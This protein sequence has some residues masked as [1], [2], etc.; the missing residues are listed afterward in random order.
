MEYL[1]NFNLIV[2]DTILEC[3]RIEHDIKIIY[4]GMLSGDYDDNIDKIKDKPLGFV[5]NK[6]KILDN[7]DNNPYFSE[8]DYQLLNK[9]KN[10]R[11]WLVHKAYIE[12]IYERNQ[13]WND[14]YNK[15]FIKLK[16]FNFKMK[17]LG[18]QVENIRIDI[19]KTYGRA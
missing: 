16:D 13:R 11:N 7:S 10:I 6:L 5:L 12:F 15:A 14:N 17:N 18:N 2:G 9:I 19:M 3:Q 1:D 4:A 8:T